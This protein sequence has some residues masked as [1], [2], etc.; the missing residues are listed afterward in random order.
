MSDTT[1]E[2]K[3]Q[4]VQQVRSRYNE[5]QYDMYNRERILCGE[6]LHRS[7]RLGDDIEKTEMIGR[8]SFFKVRFL[9]ALLFFLT[10]VVMDTNNIKVAGI[11]VERIYQV[12][13]ADYEEKLEVWME[14][15]ADSYNNP[16]R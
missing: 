13:S 5:N 16:Q 12:I 1:M 9:F 11:T 14:T 2:Q 3:L 15:L 4:L 6:S 8:V 7:N 10:I